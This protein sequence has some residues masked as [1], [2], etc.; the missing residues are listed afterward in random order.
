VV[1]KQNNLNEWKYGGLDEVTRNIS[2]SGKQEIS[3]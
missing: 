2:S 3:P 1:E